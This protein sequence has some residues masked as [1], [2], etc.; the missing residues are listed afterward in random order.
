VFLLSIV[1]ALIDAL[2]LV[3]ISFGAGYLLG[4][5]RTRHRWQRKLDDCRHM[6][7]LRLMPAENNPRI[8]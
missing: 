4:W 6:A 3:G 7:E 2:L 1:G 8:K 5:R